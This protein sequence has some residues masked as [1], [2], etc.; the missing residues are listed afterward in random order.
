MLKLLVLAFLCV[1]I[2]KKNTG[3]ISLAFLQVKLKKNARI[4]SS[5]VF[6]NKIKKTL[7]LSVSAFLQ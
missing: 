6:T 2:L 5:S 1:K 7:K 4:N 3:T